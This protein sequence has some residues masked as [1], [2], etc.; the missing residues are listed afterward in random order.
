[1]MTVLIHSQEIFVEA[2]NAEETELVLHVPEGVG[3]EQ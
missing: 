2:A 1:M 3:I